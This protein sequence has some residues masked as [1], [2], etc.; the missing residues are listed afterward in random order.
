[1]PGYIVPSRLGHYPKPDAGSR[2][3]VDLAAPR[4]L[5]LG[6]PLCTEQEQLVALAL[7]PS[8]D[9][10]AGICWLCSS[11]FWRNS[12]TGGDEESRITPHA[13]SGVRAPS[14]GP[15]VV[16]DHPRQILDHEV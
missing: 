8:R 7:G 1:M 15:K 12:G 9:I 11:H 5:S 2:L 4:I 13:S 16:E 6:L 3:R 10:K 14:S